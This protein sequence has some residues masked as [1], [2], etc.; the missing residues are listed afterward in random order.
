MLP[1]ALSHND[2]DFRLVYDRL[3]TL[4]DKKNVILLHSLYDF[5]QRNVY[6]YLF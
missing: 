1:N 5:L 6:L 3:W 2:D 4:K